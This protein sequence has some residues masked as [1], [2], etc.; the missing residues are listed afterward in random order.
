MVQ[1]EDE[2]SDEQENQSPSNLPM[3]T[4]HPDSVLDM[5]HENLH[6]DALQSTL[7]ITGNIS[8]SFANLPSHA[9]EQ[10]SNLGLW[11]VPQPFAQ[12]VRVHAPV[13]TS[14]PSQDPRVQDFAFPNVGSNAPAILTVSGPMPQSV[15]NPP[16][17]ITCHS[18]V[19]FTI[20]L[21]VVAMSMGFVLV[22]Y[23]TIPGA[24]A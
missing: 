20:D 13:P 22:P 17:I 11:N 18:P 16:D 10:P 3:L 19:P 12:H 2:T 14:G 15:N 7:V 8:N 21:Q 6:N 1:Q 24:G 5:P 9:L 23:P 4:H